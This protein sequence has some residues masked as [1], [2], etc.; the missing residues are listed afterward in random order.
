MR[1]LGKIL[2]IAAAA[3]IVT[4]AVAAEVVRQA[5]PCGTW[6]YKLTINVDTPEGL[7][8]GSAVREVEVCLVDHLVPEVA[9]ADVTVKGEAVVVDLGQRG[10]LFGIMDIDGSRQLVFE[11][12]PGPI[13]YSEEG[14]KYYS[15]L[16]D[17]K[18][19]SDP[20]KYPE[21]AQLVTFSNLNDPLTVKGVHPE[22]P[23]VV[24]GEGV[25]IQNMTVEMTEEPITWGIEEK[26]PWLN[27]IKGGY[28]HGELT[29]RKAP[30]GLD[31][32]NFKRGD[33][34]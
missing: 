18:I 4:A 25:N 13:P 14:L 8:S 30:L 7:K 6:R 29:S 34:K 19:I 32:G 27:N 2:G 9:D 12:F 10:V 17:S 21:Y 11:S 20:K 5:V 24:F 23:D 1:N 16:K 3:L 31:G 22:K 33:R 26:L 28:L 15:E